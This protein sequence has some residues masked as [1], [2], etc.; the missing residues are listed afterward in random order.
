M[1][2]WVI[3]SATMLA[4][5]S[6]GF[7]QTA[8]FEHQ[9]RILLELRQRGHLQAALEGARRLVTEAE[10]NEPRAAPLAL[11][12]HDYAVISGD[13]GLY[14]E[15]EKALR[16]AIRLV[17]VAEPTDGSV[18]QVLRLRLAELLLDAGRNKEAR[19]LFLELAGKWEK[20]QPQS[21]E[22]AI[23]L[24]HLGWLEVLSRHFDAAESLLQR[25][26]RIMEARTDVGPS[27]MGDVLNDYASLL[28]TLKRYT[29]AASYAE[30]VMSLLSRNGDVPDATL[31]NAWTMLAAAYAN[32]GR[33]QE[34]QEYVRQ[35]IAAAKS[36]YG[37][38]SR[39]AGR[40]MTVGA[41]LLERCGQ[42][43]EAKALRKN[44]DQILAKAERD[45]PRRF[46]VDVN[47]LR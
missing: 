13:L 32:T 38:D 42:K 35:A 1:S 11:A 46:T 25:S 2:P 5:A 29:E 31:I 33:T 16:R 12:L 39:R 8:G 37:E 6:A 20:T 36:N 3:A 23:A 21:A 4:Y 14:A 22:L 27:Q 18:I 17:E 45:D 7:G 10:R 47:A 40:L 28:F 43:S 44:A 41:V 15:S 24:D 30:R 34:A 9:R 26:I 19:S